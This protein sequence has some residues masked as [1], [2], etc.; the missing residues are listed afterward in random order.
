MALEPGT[1]LM[2]K[3]VG[4]ASENS[5]EMYRELNEM[6]NPAVAVEVYG[7]PDVRVPSPSPPPETWFHLAGTWDGAVLRLW[8]DGELANEA[9]AAASSFDEHPVRFGC[10]DDAG[11]SVYHFEGWLADV[12]IYGTALE[13]DA[14][15]TIA[16]S[17]PPAPP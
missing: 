15:A 3:A 16:A 9:P 8:I 1:F 7:P 12:R 13:A 6:A 17:P 14:L 11:V 2:G 10:D 5:W 4:D